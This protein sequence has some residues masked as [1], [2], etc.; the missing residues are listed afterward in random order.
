[1]HD[2]SDAHRRIA[3]AIR[4]YL[5]EHPDAADSAEGIADWWLD[6]DVPATTVRDV[7]DSLVR[8]GVV[9]KYE[10]AGG[11]VIYRSRHRPNRTLN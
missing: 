7:L 1:M 4:R 9:E 8:E 10:F 3:E 11:R 6:E 5:A 2:P